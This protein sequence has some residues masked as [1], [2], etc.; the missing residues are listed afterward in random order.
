MTCSIL[1][2][3]NLPLPQKQ[4]RLRAAQTATVMTPDDWLN[5]AEEL[6]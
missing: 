2:M 5:L 3:L 1:V 6:R 4:M